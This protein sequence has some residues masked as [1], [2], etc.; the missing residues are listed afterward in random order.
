MTET[1]LTAVLTALAEQSRPATIDPATWRKGKR[2]RRIRV[3]TAVAAVLM[4]IAAGPL[5]LSGSGWQSM[6]PADQQRPIVPSRVYPPL[7]GEDTIVEAPGGPAAILVAGDRELRGSDIWGWEGRSLIVGQNGSYRLA[8]TVG[9]TTAGAGGLLLSPDGR[10]LAG[11]PWIEGTHWPSSGEQQVAIVD[12]ST[13]KAV[14]HSGGGPVAWA[15]DGRSIL[16][17]ESVPDRPQWVGSLRLLDVQTGELRQLPPVN[18]RARAGNYAAFSADGARLAIATETDLYVIGLGDSSWRKLAT[19]SSRDRIAGPGAWLPDGSRIAV[20]YIGGC[21]EPPCDETQLSQRLFQVEYLD[22]QTGQPTAGPQLAPAMGLAARMLGWQR[23]GDAVVAVYSPEMD[24]VRRTGDTYW[25]E[26]DWWTVGGVELLEFRADGSR[27]RLVE[28]PA[29][30]LFVEV[31]A[32]LLDRFGGPSPTVFEGAVRIVL[33][34]YWPV[35]QVGELCLV[36]V[37]ASV[38]TGWRRRRRRQ[39]NVTG[40]EV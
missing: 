20:Y 10:Y 26:T 1:R 35:G 23:D 21:E 30:A 31:P 25:S 11:M 9:E 15:P 32:D 7:T 3:V 40:N 27:H 19:L 29:S 34:V 33:A 18:G 38:V 12:L 2:R 37:I 22:A 24:A 14:L 4:V 8:R 39:R 13:G 36:I 16:V 17:E 6:P 5:L 28:L